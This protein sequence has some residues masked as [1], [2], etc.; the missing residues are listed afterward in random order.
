MKLTLE[1]LGEAIRAILPNA[2]FDEY[3]DGELSIAT[4][5]RLDE[6]NNLVE[7]EPQ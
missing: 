7:V 1:E 5:L 4:G 6:N 3:G 2:I